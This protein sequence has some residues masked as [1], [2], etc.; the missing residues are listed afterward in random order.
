M[1]SILSPEQEAAVRQDLG[2]RLSVAQA[3]QLST[4]QATIQR[5]YEEH[6]EIQQIVLARWIRR[7]GHYQA[8]AC[9]VCVTPQHVRVT[10]LEAGTL[11]LHQPWIEPRSYTSGISIIVPRLGQ[12]DFSLDSGAF[13]WLAALEEKEI[14]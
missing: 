11:V 6:L 14:G 9:V 4:N 3:H 13:P 1:A 10:L 7:G 12:R 8:K 5:L 2:Y